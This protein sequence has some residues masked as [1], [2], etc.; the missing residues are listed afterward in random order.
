[1]NKLEGIIFHRHCTPIFENFITFLII[2]GSLQSL[3]LEEKPFFPID[4]FI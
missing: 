2:N 3:A 4:F 1:M